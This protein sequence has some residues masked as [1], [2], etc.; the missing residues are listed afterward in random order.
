MENGR[1]KVYVDEP[2]CIV[3]GECIRICPRGARDYTDDTDHFLADLKAGK[4]ISIIAAPALRSNIP[5]WPKLLGYLGSVGVDAVYD[6]SFGADIC[7]WAYLRYMTA[8]SLAPLS[9]TT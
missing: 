3:C 1:N 2:K 5:E 4:R 7:T 6:T 9:S 8:N